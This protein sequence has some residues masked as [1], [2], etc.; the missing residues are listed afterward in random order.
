MLG[1][2]R[3][4]SIRAEKRLLRSSVCEW[5]HL[6]LRVSSSALRYRLTQKEAEDRLAK[7]LEESTPYTLTLAYKL[8]HETYQQRMDG[9]NFRLEALRRTEFREERC[10]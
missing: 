3:F 6:H 9:I 4:P 2:A 8:L 1:W 10:P 5:L 7:F